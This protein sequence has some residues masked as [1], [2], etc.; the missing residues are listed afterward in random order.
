MPQVGHWSSCFLPPAGMMGM[1]KKVMKRIPV[2]PKNC[3]T[4]SQFPQRITWPEGPEPHVTK[5]VPTTKMKNNPAPLLK[6]LNA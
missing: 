4:V 3:P 6:L 1:K 2:L 5:R